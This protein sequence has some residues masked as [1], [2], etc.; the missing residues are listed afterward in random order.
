MTGPLIGIQS[1]VQ[2]EIDG[3]ATKRQVAKM[4]NLAWRLNWNLTD[5]DEVKAA[6]EK[7]WGP[8]GVAEVREMT[9]TGSCW[10]EGQGHD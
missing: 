9:M 4:L 1:C 6:V 5:W 2:R 10:D 8:L 3:G 7:K